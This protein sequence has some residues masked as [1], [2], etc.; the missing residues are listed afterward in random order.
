MKLTNFELQTSFEL[1]PDFVNVF[2]VESEDKFYRY[3]EELLIGLRE[4]GGNFLLSEGDCFLPLGKKCLLV[5]DLLSLEVEGKKQSAKLFAELKEIAECKY[6]AEVA[7]LKGEIFS[8]FEKLNGE[9]ACAFDYDE[10]RGL[11]DI[12][13]AFGVEFE[14]TYSSLLEKLI[15]FLRIHARYFAVKVFFFVN[16][17]SFLSAGQLKL[18]FFEARHENVHLFFLE[19]TLKSGDEYEKIVVVDR[20]LCEFVVKG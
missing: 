3:C 9:S 6:E 20:D 17:K 4:N 2:V 15:A 12:F 7:R 11:V 1:S 14:K 18:L 10:E 13:K 5:S 8:L 19:N 16:L